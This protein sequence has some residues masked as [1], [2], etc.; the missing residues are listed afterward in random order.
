VSGKVK[1]ERKK[2]CLFKLKP[3][4]KLFNDK[5]KECRVM[6]FFSKKTTIKGPGKL[7]NF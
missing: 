3:K 6:W 5:Y 7:T 4:V 2:R 1:R